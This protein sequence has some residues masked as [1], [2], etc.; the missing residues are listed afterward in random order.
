[1]QKL[2]EHGVEIPYPQRVLHV[3][4]GPGVQSHDPT[5]SAEV[6]PRRR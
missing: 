2:R 5:E 4:H 1:L 6:S 3:T